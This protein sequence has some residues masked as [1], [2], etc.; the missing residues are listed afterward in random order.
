MV[1]LLQL[2]RREVG[3]VAHHHFVRPRAAHDAVN[4][5]GGA[6][7]D[8]PAYLVAVVE[9]AR[10]LRPRQ[11]A[12]AVLAQGRGHRAVGHTRA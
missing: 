5:A 3:R 9:I 4:Q 12:Q 11:F 2:R 10:P 1:M 8:D 6:T 7:G